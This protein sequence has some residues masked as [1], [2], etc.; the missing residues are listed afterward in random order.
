[1]AATREQRSNAG[2]RMAKLLNEE[3]EDDFYKTTYGGFNEEDDDIDFQSEESES[4]T[5][6]SDFSI[7]ENDEVRSDEDSEEPRKKRR[8]GVNTKAYKEPKT[9]DKSKFKKK[10]KPK[11]E[12]STVQI[13]QSVSSAQRK[14]VRRS[15]AE[16]SQATQQREKEREVRHKMMR[17]IAA[18]KNVTEVR[19]LTQAELLEEAKITE[20]YNLKS[21]ETYQRLES[22][23]KKS[24]V[25]KTSYKGPVIRYQSVTMPLIE[26]LPPT[27]Q[28]EPEINV[29][30]DGEEPSAD[31]PS[32]KFETKDDLA[33]TSPNK[34]ERRPSKRSVSGPKCSRTFIT[35]TDD[36][37]FRECFPQI[38]AKPPSSNSKTLCPVTRQPAKYMDP[39]TQTPYAT[40]SAFKLLREAF[41]QQQEVHVEQKRKP[42]TCTQQGATTTTTTAT[43]M[44]PSATVATPVSSSSSSIMSSSST[45]TTPSISQV[46]SA[47]QVTSSTTVAS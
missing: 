32:T 46:L 3:E 22:E 8:A 25:Q 1:M 33:E 5:V 2:S 15:T 38:K 17:E 24:R 45:T 31:S 14:S 47:T 42:R 12:R 28:S 21:L 40:I 34:G 7:D 30:E 4:D 20:E 9:K 6:D 29:E 43:T 44:A 35:F 10:V 36:K 41:A 39:I 16:K 11:S 27:P 26:Q 18:R 19:R 23:K 13:Y 37:R